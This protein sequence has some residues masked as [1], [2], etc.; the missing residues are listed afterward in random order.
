MVSHLLL[1]NFAT[2]GVTNIN[3][4]AIVVNPSAFIPRRNLSMI[5]SERQ[6]DQ[7]SR[8]ET[9][10]DVIDSHYT[11]TSTGITPIEPITSMGYITSLCINICAVI[12][13]VTL[14]T[15]PEPLIRQILTT[16]YQL[17]INQDWD[18]WMETCGATIPHLHFH[19]YLFIDRIW[20]ILDQ[21]A[22]EFNN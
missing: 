16:I 3:N 1:G 20:A 6:K 5:E 9:G 22:T 7:N 10:M 11:K 13:A 4:E 18:K 2:N 8:N 19:F 14:Y 12:L 21:G 15:G 17:T